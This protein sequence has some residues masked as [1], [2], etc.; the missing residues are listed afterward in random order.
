LSEHLEEAYNQDNGKSMI[1]ENGQFL[2][3]FYIA[4]FDENKNTPGKTPEPFSYSEFPM[5]F[6][7]PFKPINVQLKL[8]LAKT[9]LD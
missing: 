3:K 9:A 1:I 6:F 8:P 7:E 5:S 4:F 2:G